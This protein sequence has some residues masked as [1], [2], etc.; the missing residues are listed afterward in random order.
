MALGHAILRGEVV[1]L[2]KGQAAGLVHMAG[3]GGFDRIQFIPQAEH[4]LWH[5]TL[6]CTPRR[7]NI[8]EKSYLRDL[9]QAADVTGKEECC[10]LPGL[11]PGRA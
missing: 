5:P 2:V 8:S 7:A 6:S 1:G 3:K 9:R 11:R 4:L 10:V